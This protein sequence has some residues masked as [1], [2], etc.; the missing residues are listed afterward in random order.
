MTQYRGYYIDNV[1]FSSKADIDEFVKEQAIRAYKTACRL[2][3]ESPSMERSTYC[4]ELAERLHK[5]FGFTW[6]QIEAMELAIYPA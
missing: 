6:D 4:Y 2:F 1:I 5:V 3:Y